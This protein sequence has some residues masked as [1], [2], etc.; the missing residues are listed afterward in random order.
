MNHVDR[1]KYL[2]LLARE[3]ASQYGT[4]LDA[5]RRF[6]KRSK[7]NNLLDERPDFVDHISMETWSKEVYHEMLA[8]EKP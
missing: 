2:S 4:Q 3:I 7:I 8:S 6:V 5:T 1:S